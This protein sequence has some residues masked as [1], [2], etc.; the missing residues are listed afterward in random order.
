MSIWFICRHEKIPVPLSHET[1][2]YFD[3]SNNTELMN[4]LK[5]KQLKIKVISGD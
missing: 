5:D 2:H 4:T 3:N 1:E